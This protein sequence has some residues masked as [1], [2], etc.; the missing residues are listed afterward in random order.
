MGLPVVVLSPESAQ[1]L[2]PNTERAA[3]PP[4]PVSQAPPAGS[5]SKPQSI[6]SPGSRR[7]V[8]R[9][10]LGQELQ[11]ALEADAPDELLPHE[12]REPERVE[13][14]GREKPERQAIGVRPRLGAPFQEHELEGKPRSP[15]GDESVYTVAVRGERRPG[16][17]VEGLGKLRG[18]A[19]EADGP[20]EPVHVDTHHADS[21]GQ[22]ACRKPEHRL[23]LDHA[24]LS[25]HEPERPKRVEV[26][27][28]CYVRDARPV[29]DDLDLIVQARD[30]ERAARA[31]H[32]E[33][34]PHR[35]AARSTEQCRGKT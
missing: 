3:R 35:D 27:V 26:A 16:L 24:V 28:R 30:L 29:E 14:P 23:H 9:G 2:E 17:G 11:R 8:V 6:S 4:T 1:L 22:P 19:M 18:D 34:E 31:W 15:A 32:G 13:E 5:E 21:L 7:V 10:G 33:L 20:H 25:H 12:V